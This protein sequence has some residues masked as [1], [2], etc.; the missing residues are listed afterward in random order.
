MS[1]RDLL[2]A[3]GWHRRRTA[4]ALVGRTPG[5]DEPGPPW[6]RLVLGTLLA[7]LVAVVPGVVAGMG[8]SAPGGRP[9][10]GDGAV[11]A[12]EVEE[13]H[14]PALV[15][16][17]AGQAYALLDPPPGAAA[18]AQDQTAV[19]HPV[20]NAVAARLVL[21]EA[22]ASPVTAPADVLASL[23]TGRPLGLA[24]A[25]TRLPEPDQLATGWT[26]CAGAR[27]SAT[28]TLTG[29]AA[30]T[31]SATGA[32]LV[33]AA[34]TDVTWLVT[35]DRA[36]GL[37]RL[38]VPPGSD[39]VLA[40]LGQ[41]AARWAR[42]VPAAW[43]GLLPTG[44]PL[45]PAAFADVVAGG[46]LGRPA[47]GRP[48]GVRVGDHT[49]S[50]SR[51]VDAAGSLRPLDRFAARVWAALAGDLPARATSPGRLVQGSAGGLGPA[52]RPDG[53]PAAVPVVGGDAD[54]CLSASTDE[55]P[56]WG[57][58]PEGTGPRAALVAA[59]GWTWLVSDGTRHRLGPDAADA[60]GLGE[61]TP[62]TVPASWLRLVEAGPRLSAAAV[63]RGGELR[64][65]QRGRR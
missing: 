28:L 11:V 36:G 65:G 44:A 52:L 27:G 1:R 20:G 30:S 39:E 56:A 23:P 24:G 22:A 21:G 63:L 60:L 64:G 16:D 34:G 48:A 62:L 61:A 42:T 31:G 3:E 19:L 8:F 17:A 41:P 32:V 43:V 35:P 58:V 2:E 26:V 15:L 9:T 38:R 45:S 4:A 53:W 55:E 54:L 13:L 18:G 14:A 10:D 40:A 5:A 33:R 29:S 25:P 57:L 50:G 47:P 46:R 7:V 6:R 12:R 59:T 37:V 49:R 51:V